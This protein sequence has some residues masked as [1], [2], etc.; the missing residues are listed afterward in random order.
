MLLIISPQVHVHKEE[1]SLVF[2][3]FDEKAVTSVVDELSLEYK[4]HR[5]AASSVVMKFADRSTL[6][7]AAVA[8]K[9]H[10]SLLNQQ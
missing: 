7:R 6:A 10:Y 2:F 4:I 5:Q 9:M 1:C 8:L 3:Q